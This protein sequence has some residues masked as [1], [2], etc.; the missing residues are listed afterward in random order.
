MRFFFFFSFKKIRHT[1]GSANYKRLPICTASSSSAGVS[2]GKIN[3]RAQ[4][5][6]E[7]KHSHCECSEEEERGGGVGEEVG[8][9]VSSYHKLFRT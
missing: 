8:G 7:G 4:L 5:E 2:V 3:W 9:G 1:L 6:R